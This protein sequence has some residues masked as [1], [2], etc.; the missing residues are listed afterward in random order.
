MKRETPK[1]K[2]LREG[3]EIPR[4]WWNYFINPITGYAP[5]PPRNYYNP[6]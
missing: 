4:D 6:K 1:L 5:T 3:E 2:L